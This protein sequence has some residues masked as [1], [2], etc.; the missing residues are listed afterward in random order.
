LTRVRLISE[1]EAVPKGKSIDML[2]DY[3]DKYKEVPGAMVDSMEHLTEIS[4]DEKVGTILRLSAE[5][6]FLFYIS[7]FAAE[8]SL[9]VSHL[10]IISSYYKF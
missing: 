4:R 7:Q 9:S 8:V 6:H 5:F 3:V 10:L 2:F 1:Y